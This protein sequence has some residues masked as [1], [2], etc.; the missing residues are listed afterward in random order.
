MTQPDFSQLPSVDRILSDP[1]VQMLQGRCND[2][3]LTDLARRVVDRLRDELRKGEGQTDR[4]A[5]VGRA[6][7]AVQQGLDE[8]LAPRLKRVINATG[9]IL[10]TNLG[11]APLPKEAMEQIASV[12]GYY[13]NLEV[14]LETGKR[15]SRTG[16]IEELLCDLTGAEAAVIV[17]NNAAAV[18]L[19]L[20]TLSS[21]KEAVV[22]RGELIEIGGSFRIPDIM[23]RSGA[24]MVEVGTTN[25]THL[26]D[27]E[28]VLNEHTGLMLAVHPSNY[29]VLGFTA[30]VPLEELVGLGRRHSVPVAHDLGGG[31]LVDLREY[32]LP[33]E[34]LVSDSVRAGADVVTFSGDKI[35]GG[36]QAGILVGK[37]EAIEQV[38]KNPLM[39]A[40]RC[41]KLT[42]AALEATLKLYLN[43]EALLKAHPTL[44]M[45]TEP[46]PAL[47]RRGRRLLKHLAGLDLDARFEE[48]AAQTGSGAL[49][50]EEIPSLAITLFPSG[51]S[52]EMFSARL[53]NFTPPV[54]GYVRDNRLVLDL[55]TVRGDEIGM[56][57]EAVRRAVAG[58]KEI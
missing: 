6:V 42:Y 16:L 51:C 20:N 10:H 33:Y 27:F 29:Q 52:T 8:V 36:P 2:T 43:R 9:I 38:K 22:S 48:T 53:R 14:D 23:S 58:E 4:E 17:N 47:R 30:D 15:G 37:K 18:L 35:L 3:L 45:L 54:M 12:A 11:R 57:A 7:E 25:R 46:V 26:R 24:A 55:R 1:G 44:R 40:L 39:R 28:E 50:L 49:P 19:V 31:V 13:S 32:G 21:G 41:G 56:V 5:L 34:P